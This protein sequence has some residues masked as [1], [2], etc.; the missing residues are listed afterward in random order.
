MDLVYAKI[1]E[2]SFD[3]KLEAAEASVRHAAENGVTSVHEMADASSL[4]VFQEHGPARP[5]DDPRP[6][7]H[8]H[9]RGRHARPAQAEVAVRRSLSPAGGPQGLHGRLARLGDGLFLRAL[10]GRSEDV[11]ASQRPDV[12]R[13]DHGKADP[14][15]RSGRAATGHPRHRRP[16][17]QPAHRHV[18]EGRRRERPA[19]QALARRA[20]PAPEAG[21]YRPLR[22]ARSRGLRPALSRH[23]RRTLGR[24]QDRARAGQDD[25][26]VR[27]PAP[28]RRG[29][30]LRLGLDG[31]SVEPHPGDLRRGD[32][33]DPRREEAGRL[34]PGREGLRRGGRPGLHGERRL[35]P[36][37][38]GGQGHDLSPASWP[39]L[40]FS[41]AT[42]SPSRPRR[43]A[44]PR[45][46]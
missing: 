46:G 13:R 18:R 27:I 19:R 30:R 25:L 1:P 10:H 36:V 32:A 21:R 39:T 23:R 12:P 41:T 11:R 24:R 3:E 22:Q 29:P 15:G 43:S 5:A 34:D 40:S 26:R 42:S 35:G 45:S 6:C 7:L 20:R 2:P 9:H 8:P 33:P 17:Q 44:G 4:E 14:R 37:R 16:G 38:R 28:G 31:R